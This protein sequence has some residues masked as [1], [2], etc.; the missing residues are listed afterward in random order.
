MLFSP[1]SF[2][3]IIIEK[4]SLLTNNNNF[5]AKKAAFYGFSI[6]GK[7]YSFALN[8]SGKI[9]YDVVNEF[10]N[11]HAKNNFIIFG[12]TNQVFETLIN[13]LNTK[14]LTQNLRIFYVLHPP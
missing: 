1:T 14:K 2:L 6:F 9:D 3:S 13:K 11:K 7:N 12:F 10:L 5:D 4:K 8:S